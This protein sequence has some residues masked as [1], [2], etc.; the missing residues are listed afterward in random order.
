MRVINNDPYSM[1]VPGPYTMEFCKEFLEKLLRVQKEIRNTGPDPNMELIL[2]SEI[3]EIQ[4]IWR[5]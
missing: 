4:R 2:E 5:A 3:H 1:L